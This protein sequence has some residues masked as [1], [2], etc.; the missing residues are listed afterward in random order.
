M[1]PKIC[2]GSAQFG[3]KYGITNKIGATSLQEVQKIIEICEL[4]NIEYID[5]AIS[6]GNSEKKLGDCIRNNSKFKLITKISTQDVAKNGMFSKEKAEKALDVSFKR[7]KICQLEGLLIHTPDTLETG[8]GKS[9]LEWIREKKREG[10]VNNVGISIYEKRELDSINTKNIDIVQA[11]LSIFDQR[12]LLNKGIDW[13]HDNK[14]KIFARSIFMQGILLSKN[15][16][17]YALSEELTAH[18]QRWK[19]YLNEKNLAQLEECINFVSSIKKLEAIIVGIENASQLRQIIQ[20]RKKRFKDHITKDY[21]KWDWSKINDV[22][23]RKWQT[24]K[25]KHS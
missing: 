23:P 2:I 19:D 20:I 12:I 18:H 14:I 6:Y 10:K 9:L 11:P 3:M 24:N 13:L 17:E 22:D 7:L 5:T 21:L 15:P 1:R 16:S 8:V 4:N 25:E